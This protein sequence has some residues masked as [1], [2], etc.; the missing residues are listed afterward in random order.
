MN[1]IDP[2]VRVRK[3]VLDVSN[4]E[5]VQAAAERVKEEEGRLE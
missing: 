1:K 2:A 3:I 4:E 5:Q